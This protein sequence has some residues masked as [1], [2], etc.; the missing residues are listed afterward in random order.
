MF[1]PLLTELI[2]V[3]LRL[4]LTEL[5][6]APLPMFFPLLT[7]LIVAPLRPLLTELLRTLVILYLFIEGGFAV[8]DEFDVQ[9]LEQ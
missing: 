4:L 8:L 2:V 6:V 9:A 7:E 5:I 3:P 1:W